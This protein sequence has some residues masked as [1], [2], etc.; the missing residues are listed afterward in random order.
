MEPEMKPD[1]TSS[2]SL[3]RPPLHNAD[4]THS[5]RMSRFSVP[6]LSGIWRDL[7]DV[8]FIRKL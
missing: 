8:A 2:V 6:A 3:A 1:I 5:F 4:I 7:F